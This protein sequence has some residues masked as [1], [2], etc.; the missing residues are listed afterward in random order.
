MRDLEVFCLRV[1]SLPAI[2]VD[3]AV[4]VVADYL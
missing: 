3:A 2:F 4:V 1:V